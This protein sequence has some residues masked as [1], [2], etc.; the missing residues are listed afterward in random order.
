MWQ[1]NVMQRL[2]AEFRNPGLYI[3]KHVGGLWGEDNWSLKKERK[4]Q[5]T[6]NTN[7]RFVDFFPF[8]HQDGTEN[9]MNKYEARIS[10]KLKLQLQ[11]A[12]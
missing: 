10:S 4:S 8:V 3:W 2:E 6:Q 1:L 7:T 12:Y 9:S 5:H 11:C